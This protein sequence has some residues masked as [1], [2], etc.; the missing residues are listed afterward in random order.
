MRS[1]LRLRVIDFI[2]SCV[3]VASCERNFGDYWYIFFKLCSA[4]QDLLN[5]MYLVSYAKETIQNF[6]DDGCDDLFT[7]VV[8][9]CVA[10]N[11]HPNLNVHYAK[12]QC[13]AYH[14]QDDYTIEY[15]YRVNIFYAMIDFQ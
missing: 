7:N 10:C 2:W 12:R 4:N 13:Q 14:Q 1:G 8:S 5:D 6:K 3:H 9:F 11:I 15:Y